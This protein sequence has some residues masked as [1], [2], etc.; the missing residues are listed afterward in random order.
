M[1]RILIVLLLLTASLNAKQISFASDTIPCD[2]GVKMKKTF[3]P[4]CEAWND[5]FSPDFTDKIPVEFHLSIFN[6]DSVEIFSSDDI[7][8][9]WNGNGK[10]NFE[11]TQSFRWEMS[12]RYEKNGALYRCSDNLVLIQ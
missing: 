9:G 7:E 5:Q 1:F 11:Q 12:Y 10:D 8:K 6:K 2:P 4:S 3:C